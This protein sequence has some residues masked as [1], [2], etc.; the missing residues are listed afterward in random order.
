MGSDP[1]ALLDQLCSGLTGDRAA[2]LRHAH[3]LIRSALPSGYEEVVTG[4][5]ISWVVPL[6]TYPM[7]YN[8]QPLPLASLAAQKN[9]NALYLM[10]PYLSAERAAAFER[11][12][13]ASG[14]KLD[15]GKSCLRFRSIAE[16]DE[17]AIRN[18]IAA[19]PVAKFIAD[20]EASRSGSAPS[21]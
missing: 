20:Y 9:H 21:A 10:D 7:T 13:A 16:L 12:Y 18:A 11:A 6:A 4:K 15:M 5:M 1:A 19:V 8:K 3:A 14:K 2:A 17:A